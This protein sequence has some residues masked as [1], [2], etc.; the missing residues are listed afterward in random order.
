MSGLVMSS[1][2]T[3]EGGVAAARDPGPAGEAVCGEVGRRR[4]PRRRQSAGRGRTR[5]RGTGRPAA[6]VRPGVRS[7]A[8]FRD[9]RAVGGGARALVC[10][11]VV[12]VARRPAGGGRLQPRRRHLRHRRC[13]THIHRSWAAVSRVSRPCTACRC[14]CRRARPRRHRGVPD[15]RWDRVGE[16]RHGPTSTATAGRSNWSL[17]RL[18][19]RA[20]RVA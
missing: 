17:R 16:R 10:A 7:G 13:A 8:G 18:H 14:S 2:F 6:A 11:G 20:T 1:I 15:R 4:L 5:A 3:R 19:R 12:R 9:H